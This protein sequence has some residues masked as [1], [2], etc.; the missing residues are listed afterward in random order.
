MS[1]ISKET[2]TD[3]Y[4]Q[5]SFKN[6]FTSHVSRLR[7]ITNFMGFT[8]NFMDINVPPVPETAVCFSRQ[9][10]LHANG[11]TFTC[12]QNKR[13]DRSASRSKQLKQPTNTS[14]GIGRANACETYLDL[15]GMRADSRCLPH[16]PHPLHPSHWPKSLWRIGLF[17]VV[18]LPPASAIHPA[19]EKGMPRYIN[20]L[21]KARISPLK[22]RE[23]RRADCETSCTQAAQEWWQPLLWPSFLRRMT[24]QAFGC[25]SLLRLTTQF[26]SNRLVYSVV[27][28][29]HTLLLRKL[30]APYS[31]C[32]FLLSSITAY[33]Y[34]K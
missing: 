2:V 24:A 7:G 4:T 22:R 19:D 10:G 30:F 1:P 6:P 12:V 18:R 9:P 25:P 31:F 13:P 5:P 28:A 8:F 21:W 3:N 16:V 27:S 14:A 11:R 32:F 17:I 15:C 29:F 34:D 20:P 33:Q 23:S 26:P